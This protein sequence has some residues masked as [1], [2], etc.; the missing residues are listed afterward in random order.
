M[1]NADDGGRT[2]VGGERRAEERKGS[3]QR[4]RSARSSGSE[5]RAFSSVLSASSVV[6][7][8]RRLSDC[9]AQL[10]RRGAPASPKPA[11][12]LHGHCVTVGHLCSSA[13]SVVSVR[14]RSSALSRPLIV[15]PD[16]VFRRERLVV[17]VDGCFWHG[18]PIHYTRPKSRRAF[19]D[20][21]I[22]ENRRLP[23]LR[24]GSPRSSR[25]A[26]RYAAGAGAAGDWM[27]AG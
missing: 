11:T 7:I 6:Q 27:T 26:L 8:G 19:W 13:K 4:T 18:C 14:R 10:R 23:E 15:R 3:P 24:P 12:G 21:K 20:A 1:Q 17:F 16:F 9:V 25:C 2:T 5:P 22:A